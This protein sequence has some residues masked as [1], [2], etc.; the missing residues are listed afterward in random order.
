[1]VA[2]AWGKS[3]TSPR[4]WSEMAIDFKLMF[5]L[6]GAVMIQFMFGGSLSIA[7]EA[8]IQGTLISLAIIL[9]AWHRRQAGWRW[10]RAGAKQYLSAAS[11]LVFVGLFLGAAVPMAPPTSPH[12]LPW[13]MA[14]AQIGLFGALKALRIARG[15]E[16][17]FQ[18]DCDPEQHLEELEDGNS[19]Q[20]NWRLWAR[21]IYSAAFMVIWLE[22]LA[23]LYHHGITFRGGVAT[24]NAVMNTAM[25]D[26]GH[27]VYVTAAEFARDQTLMEIGMIGMFSVVISGLI[28]HFILRVPV[29]GNNHNPENE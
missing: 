5:A 9:A 7:D 10:R 23:F 8:A 21:R 25:S 24:P 20:P 12:M 11:A 1:M 17:E 19:P 22:F 15:S 14:G 6:H 28:L 4:S 26:H 27:T 3:E 16:A 18:A 13:Y 2:M 29:F